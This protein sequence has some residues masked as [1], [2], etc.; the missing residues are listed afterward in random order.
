MGSLPRITAVPGPSDYAAVAEFMRPKVKPFYQG[1][2]WVHLIDPTTIVRDLDVETGV[3]TVIVNPI[4]SGWARV[5]PLRNT[6]NAQRATNPTTTRIVQF[7]VEDLTRDF[8][9]GL[10]FAVDVESN[11]PIHK[12]YQYVVL[13]GINSS[14]AWQRTIDTQVDLEN[15]PNYDMTLWPKPTEAQ[16]KAY[17]WGI[18]GEGIFGEA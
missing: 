9:P 18:Y 15:R 1:K 4:W 3:Q 16:A 2:E 6:V 11:D 12:E 8:R 7:W 10:R 14:Q 13:G 5:Q 17:G